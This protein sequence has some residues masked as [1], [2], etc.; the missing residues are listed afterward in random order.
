MER[1]AQAKSIVVGTNCVDRY[2]NR[3]SQTGYK[4]C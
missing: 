2:V 4:L 1:L 3:I